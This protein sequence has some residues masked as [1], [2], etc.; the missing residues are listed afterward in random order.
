MVWLSDP[1][2]TTHYGECWHSKLEL[3]RALT[4]QWIDVAIFTQH[5]SK[6]KKSPLSAEFYFESIKYPRRRTIMMIL[7]WSNEYDSLKQSNSQKNIQNCSF[8]IWNC[9]LSGVYIYICFSTNNTHLFKDTPNIFW[10]RV[11][12]VYCTLIFSSFSFVPSSLSSSSSYV[13]KFTKSCGTKLLCI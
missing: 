2:Q 3:F 11:L 6:E 13:R 10:E 9:R 7:C 12:S 5:D 4:V 8:C 1:T